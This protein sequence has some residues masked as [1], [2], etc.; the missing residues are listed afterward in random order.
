MGFPSEFSAVPLETACVNKLVAAIEA[1]GMEASA[2]S[3]SGVICSN[4]TTWQLYAFRSLSSTMDVARHLLK[5]VVDSDVPWQQMHRECLLPPI[6]SCQGLKPAI[7]ISRQQTVGRGRQGRE[8]RSDEGVGLYVTYLIFVESSLADLGGFSLFMGVCLKRMLA[9]YGITCGL[10]W[11]NDV[12]VDMSNCRH[13]SG[14]FLLGGAAYRKLAGILVETQEIS[15]KVC[16]VSVGIGLNLRPSVAVRELGGV[17]IEELR[18]AGSGLTVA[19][20]AEDSAVARL[21]RNFIDVVSEYRAGS[22]DS[23]LC[24]WS[25]S[26]MLTNKVLVVK[27][28]NGGRPVVIRGVNESGGLVVSPVSKPSEIEVLYSGEIEREYVVSN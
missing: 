17:S 4:L 22:R 8:W 16:G 2:E 5:R 15:E 28:F 11:P 26:S 27:N 13:I 25:E 6:S 9:E 20:L 23:L 7:I 18:G 14:G 21:T 12:L 10:K 19:Y 3:V 1:R 24:E